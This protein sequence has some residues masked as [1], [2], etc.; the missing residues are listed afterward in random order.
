MNASDKVKDLLSK[1]EFPRSSRYDPE[2]MLDNYMG[3]NAVWLTEWLCETLHITPGMRILD[4]GCGK[5]VSSIF[6]A[7]EFDARVW[8]AD[9]WMSQDHNWRRVV[10]AGVQDKVCP[11]RIEAHA[12]PFPRGFFDGVISIDAYQ[13]FGTDDLYLDYLSGF[14]R[15]GGFM[16][17]VVPG[18][19]QPIGEVVPAHLTEPQSNGKRFWEDEC[20]CFHTEGWWLDHWSHT[21]KVVQVRAETMK[22][23]WRHWRDFELALQLAGKNVLP[24]DLEALEK[25]QG[26][27]L[28]LIR[29][30]AE[31]SE[32]NSE[33]LYDSS[34]GLRAGVDL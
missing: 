12:L 18:L 29:V 28:D 34:L 16:G 10:A 1:I 23:G 33:N 25:D 5:A 11:M 17:I 15:P 21:S 22:D 32:S 19:V 31:R 2:W 4:L 13:Y 20:R 9:L 24:S 7:G 14:V 8:A 27:C 30:V 6:V 3:P 26:R